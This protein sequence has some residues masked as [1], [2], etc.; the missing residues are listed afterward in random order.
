MKK[1]RKIFLLAICI[2]LA[3]I[4]SVYSFPKQRAAVFVKL[5]H[6]QIEEA[7]S[8]GHGVPAEDAV[9]F[10]YDAVNSWDGTYPMT[11]F[12]LQSRGDTYYGCYYSPEDVPLPFQNTPVILRP[13]AETHGSGRQKAT[14]V[15]RPRK[16]RTAGIFL[17][18]LSDTVGAVMII[19]K[20][21]F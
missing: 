1:S 5:Y 10:G 6:E 11:E 19:E 4:F 3:A 21:D 16:L 8:H 9:I 12:I 17:K 15:V 7:L 13:D 20:G 2:L 18:P 14:T